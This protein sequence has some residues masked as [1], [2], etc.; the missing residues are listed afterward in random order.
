MENSVNNCMRQKVFSNHQVRTIHEE[1]DQKEES[2]WLIYF[3]DI[4][5]EDE[6][7][8]EMSHYYDNDSSMISDAASPVHN[9]KIYNVARRKANS[10]NTNPK[11]RRIIHQH[12]NEKQQE[13][14]D[15]DEEE[16][17]ASSPS[18][19]TKGFHVLDGGEN[20][21]NVTSEVIYKKHCVARDTRSNINEVINE[22]FLSAEL[23]KRGLCLVPLSMFSNF[24]A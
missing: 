11:K 9:T 24:I 7:V 16:D 14:G 10:I 21:V 6:M 5:H 2:S 13:E 19:K 3:E 8:E 23:K 18:N 17:T 4:D 1:E 20:N 22:E 15:E 12:K